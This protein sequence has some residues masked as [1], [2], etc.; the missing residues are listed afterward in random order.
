MNEKALKIILF[1]GVAALHAVVLLFLVFDMNATAQD[2]GESARVMKLADLEE[3]APPPPEV[4]ELPMVEAIAETMIETDTA[5]LQ[6]VVAPGTLTV[7]TWDDYL[8][9][10]KLS[11]LPRF[12]EKE[13][14]S[15]I[16]YPPI[17]QRSGIEGRVILELFV[18]R[19]GLVQQIR[20]LQ[21]APLD[22][23]FGEAAVRAFSGRRASPA[24]VNGEPVSCRYRWPVSFV[25]K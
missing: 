9:Q 15:A 12:D 21:E 1:I 7:N 6:T 20:I 25:L 5:P 13:I 11:T 8:P 16:V 14:A 17:A 24:M 18:D 2:L 22:R 10:F 19:N 23:G 4:E 3:Q